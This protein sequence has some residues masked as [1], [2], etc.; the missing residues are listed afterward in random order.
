MKQKFQL[1]LA[2][3]VVYFV[4]GSTFLAIK[5]A[6][7]TMPAFLMMGT[8]FVIAG[9]L[10]LAFFG[11]KGQWLPRKKQW[12][13]LGIIALSMVVLGTGVVAW[14][15][16][17][18]PSGMVALIL[19]I[20]PVWLVFLESLAPN[21]NTPGVRGLFGVFTGMLGLIVLITP[22]SFGG[23]IAWLP[24]AVIL[25]SAFSWSAGSIYARHAKVDLPPMMTS[26][27]QMVLGGLCLLLIGACLGETVNVSAFSLTSVMGLVYL[28]SFGSLLVFPCYM[29]LLK[30]STPAMVGTHAYV[31]PIIALI[32]GF[33]FANEPL[34]SRT[35]LA[36]IIIIS[37]V[38]LIS[39]D[40]PK[41]SKNRNSPIFK[42][43]FPF[44][45]RVRPQLR[46]C[47]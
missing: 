5:L 45:K 4:W 17:F 13:Q 46:D 19:A 39:T 41:P 47:V 36:T 7:D 1:I 22:E 12:R 15:T 8:R 44:R 32:L 11:R 27:W 29:F 42:L 38:F 26:A 23:E 20:S 18:V 24:L 16:R 3:A 35:I 34:T 40:K 21:G 43:P 10:L 37:S 30:K 9:L 2:F 6:V 14:T 33:F 31:N 25:L 28:I